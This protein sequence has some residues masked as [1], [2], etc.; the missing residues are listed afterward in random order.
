MLR[1]IMLLA[2]IND[3]LIREQYDVRLAVVK[4]PLIVAC[5]PAMMGRDENVGLAKAL[6]E[7][8]LLLGVPPTQHIRDRQV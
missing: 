5:I 1:I 2:C 6:P 8:L 4:N 7:R 3:V